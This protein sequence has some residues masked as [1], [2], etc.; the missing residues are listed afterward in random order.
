MTWTRRSRSCDGR[1]AKAITNWLSA[2]RVR[3]RM[4]WRASACS[5]QIRGLPM[6]CPRTGVR[7]RERTDRPGTTGGARGSAGGVALRP[8]TLARARTA[9]CPDRQRRPRNQWPQRGDEPGL[10]GASPRV[11][12]AG[13]AG[14]WSRCPD[15]RRISLPDFLRQSCSGVPRLSKPNPGTRRGSRSGNRDTGLCGETLW[16]EWTAGVSDTEVAHGRDAAGLTRQ[17]PR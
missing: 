4:E 8:G 1:C 2:W 3:S 14:F 5:T 17:W 16:A 11:E 12:L 9:C 15:V 13:S 6:C 7:L 10:W